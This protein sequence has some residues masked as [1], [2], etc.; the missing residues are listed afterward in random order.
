MPRSD[1]TLRAA[2]FTLVELIIVMVVLAI[3]AGLSMPLLSGSI[4]QRH[5]K[6]EAARFLALTEY[7]RDEAV[8]QGVP[9][10]VWIDSA[11]SHFGVEPKAGFD[12]APGRN[13]D[14]AMN[15]DIHFE[16]DKAA[17]ASGGSLMP[18]EFATD[19][20]PATTSVETVRLADRFNSAITIARTKDGWSYEIL[21]EAK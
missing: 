1:P 18:V 6:D 13:R 19:G 11:T 7:A 15:P 17:N 2:G 8:S 16:I 12:G 4:R 14:F 10:S 20:S 9:M 21:K 3:V 5:L